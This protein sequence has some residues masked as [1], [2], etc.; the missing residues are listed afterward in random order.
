VGHQVRAA[1]WTWWALRRVQHHLRRGPLT[2]PE[3]LPASATLPVRDRSVVE[4]VLSRSGAT[5]LQRALVVQAWDH[6]H[7]TARAVV[8]G[9][10]AAGPSNPFRAH[11]WLD[12]EDEQ[13]GVGFLPLARLTI[14]GGVEARGGAPR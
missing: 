14:G 13:R 2:R 4:R 1:A 5:C 8:I 3:G 7:G 9:V 6:D 11:A 12:G 10:Q